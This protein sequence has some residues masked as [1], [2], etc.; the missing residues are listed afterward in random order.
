MKIT[1]GILLSLIGIMGLQSCNTVKIQTFWVSGY[2]VK[3]DSITET[4][5][6]LN[7]YKGKDLKD[8]KWKPFTAKIEGFELEEGMLQKIKVKEVQKGKDASAQFSL[9]EVL[10]Q[11]QDNRINLR[12]NWTLTTLR[13]EEPNQ[14]V[15]LPSLVIDIREMQI[16][17]K[18]GCNLYHA[19]I[20]AL[21]T[22]NIQ[23]GNLLG[24]LKACD[25]ENI[26]S[27]YLKA[28]D[29]TVSYAVEA[30]KLTFYDAEK[31]PI[32][33]FIRLMQNAPVQ[34]K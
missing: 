18:G 12:G 20:D 8:E 22:H 5:N 30:N 13:G 31:Q 11:Q 26:E 10:D 28:L 16:S 34:G 15:I 29:Q 19:Q 1:T 21:T 2:K 6:C 27:E 3:C 9:V 4:K 7:V 25:N 33:T 32:L 24:T 14:K 23:F 17:G